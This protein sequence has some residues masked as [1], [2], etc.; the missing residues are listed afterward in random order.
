MTTW[1]YVPSRQLASYCHTCWTQTEATNRTLCQR[2]ARACKIAQYKKLFLTN[3]RHLPYSP[4]LA[5]WPQNAKGVLRW[6]RTCSSVSSAKVFSCHKRC[7]TFATRIF[8][9]P[10]II[11]FWKA[12]PWHCCFC[13]SCRGLPFPRWAVWMGWIS[14][15]GADGAVE[16]R[17]SLWLNW[18]VALGLRLLTYLEVETFTPS[19]GWLNHFESYQPQSLWLKKRNATL[20]WLQAVPEV[21]ACPIF[22][23]FPNGV[24]LKLRPV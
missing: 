24:F 23:F 17:T 14:G 3:I 18:R 1:L 21:S 15:D 7:Y 8:D 20:R 22:A 2:Y 4:S 9:F 12:L 11:L 5:I 13:E 6:A 16:R 19:L 10:K